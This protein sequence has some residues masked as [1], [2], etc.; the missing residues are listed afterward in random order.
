[1]QGKICSTNKY[2]MW[3]W[4][5]VKVWVFWEGHKIWINLCRTFDKSV[6]ICARNSILVKNLTKIFQNKRGQ[7]V[8]YKLSV[9]SHYFSQAEKERTTCKAEQIH[10]MT[11]IFAQNDSFWPVWVK[12]IVILWIC[13]SLTT[14][15][16]FLNLR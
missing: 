13:S 7:V 10:K 16:I 9:E 6:I 12:I 14:V 11:T 5:L 3:R 8:L 15:I 2:I 4:L 1:M